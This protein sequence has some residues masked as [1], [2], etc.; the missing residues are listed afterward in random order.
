M[1]LADEV[2]PQ[3]QLTCSAKDP[4]LLQVQLTD[5]CSHACVDR[6]NH[7]HFDTYCAVFD[8]QFTIVPRR[9]HTAYYEA[10]LQMVR[11]APFMRDLAEGKKNRT[12]AQMYTHDICPCDAGGNSG[13]SAES[14]W[15]KALRDAVIKSVPKS[16]GSS[17]L[18]ATWGSDVGKR[19]ADARHWLQ[20]ATAP[21]VGLAF[22]LPRRLDAAS[23]LGAPLLGE[24]LET[25]KPLA[26]REALGRLVAKDQS[27]GSSVKLL[28]NLEI[29]C[30]GYDVA[31]PWRVKRQ[32]V[33]NGVLNATTTS[34]TSRKG[35][36]DV[37]DAV[38][39]LVQP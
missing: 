2:C 32:P 3:V 36:L 20:D 8:D 26:E 19:R 29:G 10:L 23:P 24:G 18:P 33:P 28:G 21:L 31:W 35:A 1:P 6:R 14:L 5:L 17:A 15:S 11:W 27:S 12:Y 13:A 7:K 38:R 25:I 22:R 39:L 37:H 34:N 16:N 9:L 4:Y 30:P